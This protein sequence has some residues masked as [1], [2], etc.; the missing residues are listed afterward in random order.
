MLNLFNKNKDK[1]KYIVKGNSGTYNVTYT[2]G[3]NTIQEPEVK[4]GWKH[5][6]SCNT[7]GYYY[8][9]AQAN[10]KDALVNVKVYK[11]GKLIN[12][13]SQEGDY[14]IAISSGIVSI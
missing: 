2:C 9:S 3:Q 1:I 10:E 4:N 6:F 5:S 14:A 13:I 11:K 7:T 12:E 8:I